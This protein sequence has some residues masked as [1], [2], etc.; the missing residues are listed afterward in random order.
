MLKNA[1]KTEDNL[2]EE[3]V[4]MSNKLDLSVRQNSDQLNSFT[5]KLEE[6]EALLDKQISLLKTTTE[7]LAKA[8]GAL[9]TSNGFLRMKEDKLVKIEKELGDVSSQNNE[10][11]NRVKTLEENNKSLQAENNK[12][13]AELQTLQKDLA[14]KV[15]ASEEKDEEIVK[16]K[17]L[18]DKDESELKVK[19]YTEGK[20][21]LK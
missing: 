3:L 4:I 20:C 16:L 9:V 10:N 13:S 12:N 17:T 18:V 21:L 19:F 5:S 2:R 1:K 8:K 6:K 14:Q 7:D 11:M 15:K